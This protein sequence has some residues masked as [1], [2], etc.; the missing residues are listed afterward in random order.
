MTIRPTDRPQ[1]PWF[2][3]GPTAK[4]PGW[5]SQAISHA[6]LGRGIR[7]PEVV[8]RFAHGLRLT[9]ALLQVP[10]DWAL[11]YVPGSDTGA[12]EAAMW[13]MLGERPVQ[14]LAFENFGKVWAT[15]AVD[16][17]KLAPE[18]IAAPW[19]EWPDTSRVDPAKDLV[20]PWNGTTSGVCA[21]DA[22]FIAGDREGLVIC[23]ATSAAFAMPL[24]WAKL[25]VV[26]FSFQKAL[27][28][29]AGLGVAALS[30]RAVERLDRYAP[31]RSI[32]KVLRLRDAKGFDRT[33]A[34]GSM[35]NTFSV[36]TIEDWIDAVEWGLSVGGLE[37]LIG[38]TKA[39]AAALDAWVGRTDWIDYL[40]ADPATRSTTSVCLKIVDPRVTAMLEEARQA[41]VRR[42]K[43]LVEAEDAAF[44]IESHRNAPAGLRIWCGCTVEA[45]DIEA[46]TPWLDWAFETALAE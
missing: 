42:M 7:A 37:A 38:R 30:P 15:D 27:G 22:D 18:V 21:P 34:A 24:P 44:D 19:G 10:A 46:L 17:L 9:R 39:N 12:V 32:P 11:V 6:L 45:A 2:S 26:T 35:I 25:D 16:H 14:V 4:R 20:F 40:A 28:G 23:D 1:R 8:E 33:L 3:A 43:A 5:S 13:S 41:L 29:E 31:P 36:W